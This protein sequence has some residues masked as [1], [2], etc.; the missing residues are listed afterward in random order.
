MT[1]YS[2]TGNLLYDFEKDYDKNILYKMFNSKQSNG[3]STGPLTQYKNNEIYQEITAEDKYTKNDTGYRIWI[4][5]RRGNG[6][7]D[8]L[9]KINRDDSGLAVIL[10]FREATTKKLRLHVTGYSQGEYWYLLSNKGYIMSFKN[11]VK[12]YVEKRKGNRKRG[13]GIPYIY[14]NRI[15]FGKK[16]QTGTGVVSKVIARLLENVG[17][18]SSYLMVKKK[19][20]LC[21]NFKRKTHKRNKKRIKSTV[22][23]LVTDLNYYTLRECSSLIRCNET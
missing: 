18:T 19:Y 17:S 3:C 6:Y 15:Y 22:K 4:D 9:K 20:V 10:G 11:Y 12:R 1:T 14:K 16:P 8:E 21:I 23:D 13:R 7:T 5:M 2:L